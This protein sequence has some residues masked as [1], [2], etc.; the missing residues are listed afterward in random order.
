MTSHDKILKW[1]NYSGVNGAFVASQLYG[2]KSAANTAKLNN[3]AKG[4]QGRS[5]SE[6]EWDTLVTIYREFLAAIQ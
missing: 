6:Q 1:L 5:F 2:E 3:K 4:N